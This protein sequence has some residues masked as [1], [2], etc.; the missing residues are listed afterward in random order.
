[1]FSKHAHTH[2]KKKQ[3]KHIV[4][5][6]SDVL[7]AAAAAVLGAGDDRIFVNGPDRHHLHH[8]H[9]HH[10]PLRADEL[11]DYPPS[12]ENSEG[13]Y[14]IDE[15]G[16][17]SYPSGSRSAVSDESRAVAAAAVVEAAAAAAAA[18]AGSGPSTL[19]RPAKFPEYK[20]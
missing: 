7:E 18:A 16:S 10:D 14:N 19:I 15:G 20:H 2:T 5:F 3:P 8:H 9:H 1:M 13:S 6:H 17:S 4:V 11:N 12:P